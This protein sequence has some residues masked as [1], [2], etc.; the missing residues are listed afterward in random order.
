MEGKLSQDIGKL[1]TKPN[2]VTRILLV[3]LRVC[4]HDGIQ[5]RSNRTYNLFY[6]VRDDHLHAVLLKPCIMTKRPRLSG[7]I[8]TLFLECNTESEL[9]LLLLM[10]KLSESMANRFRLNLCH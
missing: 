10:E 5:S 2:L 4:D 8:P 6:K 3:A 9:N 1:P 7:V